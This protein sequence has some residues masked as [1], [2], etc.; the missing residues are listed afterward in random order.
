MVNHLDSPRCV[1]VSL[2]PG[3]S[4]RYR[5]SSENRNPSRRIDRSSASIVRRG[6]TAMMPQCF[7]RYGHIRSNAKR[8]A[9]S[10]LV[11]H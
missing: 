4:A 6:S 7:L 2:G 1:K 5:F 9:I 11:P 10:A 8:A 3:R